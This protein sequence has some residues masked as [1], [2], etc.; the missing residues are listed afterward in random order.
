V[1]FRLSTLVYVPEEIANLRIIV[2]KS[3]ID[4]K[5]IRKIAEQNKKKLF[6][7]LIFMKPKADDIQ[8]ISIDKYF[9][10]YIVVGGE[11]NIEYSKNWMRNIQVDDTMQELSIYS[12]K[13]KPKS[14][15]DHLKTPCKIL[16]LSGEGRYR[17]NKKAHLTFNSKWVEVGLDRLP[18]LPFEEQ[19]E[20]ILNTLEQEF[21]KDITETRK[22]IE[23]LK[24]KIVN[25]PKEILVIHSELFKVTE[26]ALI[27]KPMYKVT[28]LNIKSKKRIS[29]EIDAITGKTQIEKKKEIH[30]SKKN[31]KTII[32]SY[33]KTSMENIDN[34]EIKTEKKKSINSL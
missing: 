9:E 32:S 24:S 17:I 3:H 13:I 27:Y 11:Y 29:I 16:K 34:L 2:Y 12:G 28:F 7:K 10:P 26:R 31:R 25:R 4:Q 21:K 22:E 8:T 23:L 30:K 5:E 20:R 19:P 14:L 6:R 18:F 1:E 15:K 33:N